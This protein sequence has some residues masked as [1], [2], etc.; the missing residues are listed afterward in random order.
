MSDFLAYVA[1]WYS[2]QQQIEAAKATMKPLVDKE[3]KM[4]K[5]LGES[6]A[7]ALGDKLKEGVNHYPL[8]D[9][10]SL[11]FTYAV[12]RAIVEADIA[13]TREA[14]LLQND[15]PIDFDALLRVKYELSKRDYDKLTPEA[16]VIISRMLTVKPKAP[17]LEMEG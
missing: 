6:I 12:D 2:L 7:T 1:E 5:A 8:E 13:P 17:T 15:R 16:K 9:G 11:K 3:L 4:R 14:Y 10:R